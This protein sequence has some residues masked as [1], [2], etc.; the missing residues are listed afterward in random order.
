MII[1]KVADPGNLA[2]R[3]RLQIPDLR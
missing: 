1:T 2:P 3:I